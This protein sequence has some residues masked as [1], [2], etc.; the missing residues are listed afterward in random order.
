MRNRSFSPAFRSML[1]CS[2]L[3]AIVLGVSPAHASVTIPIGDNSS[4]SIGAGL[5]SSF[6]ATQNGAPNGTSEGDDFS[7]ENVRVYMN[8]TITK[9]FK[10]TFDTERDSN[11]T[12]NVL[13]GYV[14][15]E[16]TDAFNIWLGRMLPPSDR[17]NLDGPYYLNTWYYPSV[18]SQYPA[19]FAGRDDGGTV[20]GKVFNK[21]LVYAV[22]AYQGHNDVKGASDQSGQLLYAARIAYNF[23]D[24]EDDPAYYT[25]S[26]YYGTQRILTLAFAG[27]YEKDGV[28][29]AAKPG[30][31]ASWNADLL[32]EVPI[33][34]IGTPTLEGAYYHYDT[35]GVAD[36]ATNFNG[37]NG[38][39]NVGGVSPGSAYLIGG[40]FL[41]PQQIGLGQFQPAARYQL[42]E[43]NL[44]H[45]D[46]R[47]FDLGVNYVIKGHNL[48]V[49]A[50]YQHD[51][52][53]G[54]NIDKFVVGI[55]G[56]I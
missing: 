26:T 9:M 46:T 11:G 14:Q 51:N 31:Y 37:A 2:T 38:T 22:G 27:Q 55:Q 8:G 13:D 30:N 23:L 54:H 39:A 24:P 47:A 4:F 52:T 16:P 42:F 15:F 36:V 48:N 19:I 40:A 34:G 56:Q 1:C 25:S 17:A 45:A 44:T 49:S 10:V 28:G 3:A 43:N 20:W 33:K 5:R 18:V 41:F 29:T 7:L 53:L 21:K 50:D 32:Y 12:I 35:G 6:S